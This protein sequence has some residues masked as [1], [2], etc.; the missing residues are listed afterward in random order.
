MSTD[1]GCNAQTK[2]PESDYLE[3]IKL[4]L[5]QGAA[6]NAANSEGVTAMHGAANRGWE[7]VIQFLAGN[8]ARLDVRD[9]QGRTPMALAES[10]KT[11]A[12]LKSLMAMHN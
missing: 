4:C 10:A 3:A 2:H 8:G 7:S 5:E 9:K 11:V 1:Q 6:I 12:L